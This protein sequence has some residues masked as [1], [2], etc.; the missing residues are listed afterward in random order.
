MI[1]VYIKTVFIQNK[2]HKDES[3]TNYITIYSRSPNDM[4]INK[5][6]EWCTRK[7]TGKYQF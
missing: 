5:N 7:S 4:K 2:D 6:N 1:L 3:E